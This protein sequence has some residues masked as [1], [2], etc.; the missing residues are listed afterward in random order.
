MELRPFGKTDMRVSPIG[1]GG[2]EIGQGMTEPEIATLL[3]TILDAGINVID[4]AEDYGNSEEMIGRAATNRRNDFYLFT[5]CGHNSGDELPNYPDWDLRLIEAS[6]ERSLR[7]LHTDHIDLLQLHDCPLEILERGQIFN[8]LEKLK[9]EGKTRYIG[10]SGDNEA[11][12][13]AIRTYNFDA[14]QLSI[15]IADQQ[16]IDF[17]LPMAQER[18]L[19]VIAKRSIAEAAWLYGTPEKSAYNYRYWDRLQTLKYDFLGAGDAT[20]LSTALQFTLTVPGVATAL[21]GSS[22]SQHMQNLVRVINSEPT[23][24]D[25]NYQRIRALWE[26]RADQHWL[27]LD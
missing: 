24:S 25:D 13:F 18:N 3:N 10:Y 20:S 11:A 22:V 27:A 4:T 15:N 1:F 14:V 5:K 16:N 19:G 26:E 21:V 2:S 6:V 17:T 12:R 23:L 9:R 8:L 7:R